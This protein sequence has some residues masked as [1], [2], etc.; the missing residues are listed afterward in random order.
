MQ[1]IFEVKGIDCAN[2]AAKLE[3]NINKIKGVNSAIVS[4]ATS[5]LMIDADDD[6]FESVLEEAAALTAKLEP[7]WEIVR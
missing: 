1:K 4:F 3:K 7:D 6:V 2:C 5:K